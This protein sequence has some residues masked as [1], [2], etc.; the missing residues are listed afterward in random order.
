M[1]VGFGPPQFSTT[2][3]VVDWVPMPAR[4]PLPTDQLFVNDRIDINALQKHFINEG[5]LYEADVMTILQRA[6]A[7]F[8]T[9]PNVVDVEAPVTICGDVH[10]Q[11]YDLLKLFEIGGPVNKTT[12]LFMGDYVDRGVFSCEV[13]LLLYSLKILF[14][15]TFWLLRGNHESRHL[16]EYFTFKNE[17]EHKYGHDLYEAFQQSFDSLPIAAIVNGQFL[18]VHGGLSPA[19][20]TV[21]EIRQIHRFREPPPSGAFCDLLWADPA[22]DFDA[23][24]PY[25]HNEIR[26]CSFAFNYQAAIQFLDRNNLLCLVR[27]HEAQDEGYK[28]YSGREGS[29][30]P[31]VIT[32]FSA[33][34]YLDAYGNKAAVLRYENNVLNIRQ[35]NH[36]SHP[37][38]LPNFLDVFTWSLP[39]VGEKIADMLMCFFKLCDDPESENFDEFPPEFTKEDIEHIRARR[40]KDL[41]DKIASLARFRLMM[42]TLRTEMET[43]NQI[44]MMSNAGALPMGILL[45]GPTALRQCLTTF[46]VARRQDICNERR[47]PLP[48][49]SP[50]APSEESTH[51]GDAAQQEQPPPQLPQHT[52][53]GDF[54]KAVLQSQSEAQPQE[55][56]KE[57]A[58]EGE[59]VPIQVDTPPVRDGEETAAPE[60]Q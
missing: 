56:A 30:F 15:K 35:F 25:R 33:P 16:S 46:S 17:C 24:L 20:R 12:Y 36:V 1:P 9:E 43:V 50:G 2:E 47:P 38:Y 19:I 40:R 54:A 58:K 11:F 29:S 48:G 49:E 18:C 21:D 31:S 27:A 3:R 45:D 26:G 32:I 8:Q 44:K 60:N 5:K 39:F 23:G 55:E 4:E 52:T 7:I 42:N 37:Y 28:M 51:E 13:V 53:F 41:R 57:Q 22:E 34:N 59:A 14:P 10:G 6:Q